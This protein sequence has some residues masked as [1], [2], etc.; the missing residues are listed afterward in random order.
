[1]NVPC[2]LTPFIIAKGHYMKKPDKIRQLLEN[3]SEFIKNNPENLHIFIEDSDVIASAAESLCFEYQYTL[4]IVITD[5]IG[6][7]DNLMVPIVAWM[8]IN[9]QEIMA[10]PDLRK[11]AIK[12]EAE[13][14]N[15]S[16]YD[17]GI[18]LRLSERVIVKKNESGLLYKH[19]NDEPPENMRPNWINEIWPMI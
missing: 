7:I 16:A 8:Y 5:F 17:I 4:D 18:K 15:N 13:Q 14:L 12:L 3:Q 11:G 6:P 2:K 10:N 1:M 19:V 9:Q